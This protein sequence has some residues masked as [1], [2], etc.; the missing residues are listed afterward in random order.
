MTTVTFNVQ[1]QKL[2]G[3]TVKGH[4]GLSP[5]GSDILCAAVSSSVYLV[6][7]TITD[8]LHIGAYITVKDA[9]MQVVLP[10]S[11]YDKCQHL[12]LGLKLHLEQLAKQ[13]PDRLKV[14]IKND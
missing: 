9:F 7:N 6:A 13:Y 8:V 4:T 11:G 1:N 3:Y 12:L 2:T 5:A 10:E 14:I